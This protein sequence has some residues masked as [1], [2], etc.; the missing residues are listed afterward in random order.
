MVEILNNKLNTEKVVQQVENNGAG[1]INVFIGTVRN[2][3][4][5]NEVVK[6][7]YEAYTP[8]A[9]SEMEKICARAREKWEIFGIAIQHR[10]GTLFPGEAA[11][12][13]AVSTAHRKDSFDACEFIIDTIKETVPIW[14]KEF[15]S[16]GEVWVSANP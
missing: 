8:M 6:L 16:D 14:K 15:F 12:V 9:I 13:I 11:V 3:T 4:K 10:V 1:A 2:Q 7:E 5:G